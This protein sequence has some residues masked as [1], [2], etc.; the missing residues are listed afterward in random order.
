MLPY[1][2]S[3]E[4]TMIEAPQEVELKLELPPQDM[5]R[6]KRRLQRH[7]HLT[8]PVRT[9]QLKSVYYDTDDL[10]LRNGGVTLRVRHAGKRR[11]QTIKRQNG[12]AAGLFDRTEWEREIRGDE[13]DLGAA[14][15]TALEPILA[16]KAHEVLRPVFET[17]VRRTVFEIGRRRWAVKL[18]LD[19][20]QVVAARRSSPLS[21]AEIEL[22]RGE[23]KKLF[24]IARSLGERVLAR[25]AVKSKSDRGYEL[26]DG[27]PESAV[28]PEKIALAPGTSTAEAFRL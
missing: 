3:L 14:A 22:Q 27:A 19:Q 1:P 25:L 20:G 28:K 9:E 6:L 16:K 18:A 11:I 7:E 8:A 4:T 10:D 23:P 26:I 24:E 17:S 15:G 2:R 21:E 13:P 5:A 12:S